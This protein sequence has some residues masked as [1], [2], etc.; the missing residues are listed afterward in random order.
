MK[1]TETNHGRISSVPD[2]IE[3]GL[4]IRNFKLKGRMELHAYLLLLFGL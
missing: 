2:E 1:K 3:E 4:K